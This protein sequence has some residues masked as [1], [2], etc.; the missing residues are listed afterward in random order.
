MLFIG[1]IFTPA[2]AQSGIQKAIDALARDPDLAHASLGIC[3][4]DVESG[5]VI[6]SHDDQR[7]M[8]PASNLKVLT[9]ATAI[10]LLGSDY[11]FKTEL[12]YSGSIDANGVLNGDIFIVGYG[13]PT[14][15]SDQM[16]G[17]DDLSAVMAKFRMAIQ[18]KGIRRINGHIVG[19]DSYF[20]STVN[21]PNWHWIDLGNYYGA[22][23]WGLN[24]HENLYYL[25]FQKS[26]KLG[27]TPAVAS[28]EPS[29]PEL[30]FYNEVSSARAGSG[31]NAY[32]YGAPFSYERYLRGTIPVGQGR[33]TIKGSMPDPPLFAA[34]ELE[35]CL[36][37]VGILTNEPSLSGRQF[38]MRGQ[39]MGSANVLLTHYSPKLAAIVER[40]NIKSVNLYCEVMLRTLGK[41]KGEEGSID[42]G[43][44][45]I[46]NFWT[47]RG[48]NFN[49][50]FLED[51]SGL[52]AN[53]VVTANFMAS[54]MRKI[55]LD[56]QLFQ[57][58]YNSLP[59]A[60]KSGGM[61]YLLKGTAADGKVRAKTGTLGKV[62]TFT[63]YGT[64]RAGKLLAFCMMANY[65]E[66]S[67]GAIRQKLA[68]VMRTL[69]E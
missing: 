49:G 10:G 26:N 24:I 38:R 50:I 58:I 22:G 52:S 34:R 20:T 65:Y 18:Q 17:A 63:G 31:D 48:L 46:R 3:V 62:R 54:L 69:C 51:G 42:E 14:L 57:P 68:G 41:E 28:V 53:N 45:V 32:I 5:Q 13:D 11:Q 60:G 67:S 27:S 25:H 4:I 40:T 59:I 2:F 39:K 12:R 66:G 1:L 44:K 16:E 8:I 29:I 55:A 33:F 6:A 19:E 43:L 7:S 23:I 47:D 30:R 64:S 35:A 15:G 61:Q 9:T 21:G 36:Q 56:K 37:S